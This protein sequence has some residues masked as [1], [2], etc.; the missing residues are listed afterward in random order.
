MLLQV[1]EKLLPTPAVSVHGATAHARGL[2]PGRL[3]R[4]LWDSEVIEQHRTARFLAERGSSR[5]AL[6]AYVTYWTFPL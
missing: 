2:R 5:Q 6:G 1:T 3:W 4:G